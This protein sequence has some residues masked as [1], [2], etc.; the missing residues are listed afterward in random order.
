MMSLRVAFPCVSFALFVAACGSSGSDGAAPGGCD[1]GACTASDGASGDVT[2]P[3]GD[4]GS[5]SCAAHTADCDGNPAN[6]CETRTDDDP[7]N[8]GACGHD[9]MAG[10]CVGGSCKPFELYTVPSGTNQVVTP[11]AI[12][13][14]GTSVYVGVFDTRGGAG[15]S[16]LKLPAA[17]GAAE[18]L[19]ANLASGP[20]DIV[21]D[22]ATLYVAA[23]SALLKLAVAGGAP[24]TI[25]SW[26]TYRVA[27][28]PSRVYWT[29]NVA[30]VVR[31]SKDRVETD[32]GVDAGAIEVMGSISG[33]EG[34]AVNA[35]SIF[36]AG[37][38]AIM[39]IPIEGGAAFGMTTVKVPREVKIDDSYV[40]YSYNDPYELGVA[41]IPFGVG[42]SLRYAAGYVVDFAIDSAS[43]YWLVDGPAY[44]MRSPIDKAA[45]VEIDAPKASPGRITVDAKAVYYTLGAGQD[46][47]KVMK[48]AK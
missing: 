12:A 15:G 13:A 33:A 31:T 7:R 21:V 38:N 39:R 29:D 40:Y 10:A 46:F 4:G 23:G 17:G 43:V 6:G 41:R 30:N 45:P 14:D 22:G 8:C 35:T 47:G 3:P 19:V 48:L 26:K 28:D 18:T 37:D 25:A 34:I 27:V 9:C 42:A 2:S 44:V 1:G 36:V 5:G 32:A 20:T 24:V 16:V 11:T